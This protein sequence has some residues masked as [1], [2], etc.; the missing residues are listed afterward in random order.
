MNDKREFLLPPVR[1]GAPAAALPV[2]LV[3]RGDP[4]TRVVNIEGP[5]DDPL[6]YG[7]L[8]NEAR[9]LCELRA[10]HRDEQ[11]MKTV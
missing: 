3:I 6:L 5:I 7:S 8:L 11:A 2:T 9:R 1:L 10:N 4:E